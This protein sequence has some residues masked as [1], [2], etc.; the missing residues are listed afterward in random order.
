[1]EECYVLYYIFWAFSKNFFIKFIQF[2]LYIKKK[3]NNIE[4]SCI[5]KN[6]IYKV[7]EI[8]YIKT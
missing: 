6:K 7:E 2:S 1:M 3:I 8:Y 5:T 4:I